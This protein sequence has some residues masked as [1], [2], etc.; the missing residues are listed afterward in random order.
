MP[1]WRRVPRVAHTLGTG[2]LPH[3]G[4]PCPDPGAWTAP[5]PAVRIPLPIS[6][7]V[8]PRGFLTASRE[9]AIATDPC[10]DSPTPD[11]GDRALPDSWYYATESGTV[12]P[13]RAEELLRR[14]ALGILT[15]LTLV[16]SS[17]ADG[18]A[19][20]REL[21]PTLVKEAQPAAQ[22]PPQ[23]P[24]GPAGAG[25]SPGASAPPGAAPSR[26][27]ERPAMGSFPSP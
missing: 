26:T 4:S 25:P 3:D 5:C 15:P 2:I 1:F 17:D 14:E 13:M 21:R 20:L 8:R 12:G 22:A 6:G 18:W 10:P 16:H 27:R 9:D 24:P 11:A 23:V 7:G 19:P